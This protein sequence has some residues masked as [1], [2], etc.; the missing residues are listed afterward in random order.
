MFSY[1]QHVPKEFSANKI[2]DIDSALGILN[3]ALINQTRKP[4]DVEINKDYIAQIRQFG[5]KEIRTVV[6]LTYYY[7]II[8]VDIDKHWVICITNSKN[9]KNRIYINDKILAEKSYAAL[10]CLIE[11]SGNKVLKK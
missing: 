10:L 7:D 2:T 8:N 11:N 6:Y 4:V 5:K 3:N 1:S 9:V